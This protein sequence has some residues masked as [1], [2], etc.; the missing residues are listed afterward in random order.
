V[1]FVKN[2]C[3]TGRQQKNRGGIFNAPPFGYKVIIVDFMR[4]VF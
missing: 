3:G 4:F 2:A 1:V